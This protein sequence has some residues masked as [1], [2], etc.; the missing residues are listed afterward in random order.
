MVFNRFIL[1]A[2]GSGDNRDTNLGGRGEKLEQDDLEVLG[3][4]IDC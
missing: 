2:L 1:A 4:C 3:S